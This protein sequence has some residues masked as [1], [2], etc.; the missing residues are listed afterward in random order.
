MCSS[1]GPY[2]YAIINDYNRQV[3]ISPNNTGNSTSPPN[4]PTNVVTSIGFNYEVLAV[5]ITLAFIN[6]CL[7]IIAIMQDKR[8]YNSLKMD[9]YDVNDE[10]L[11]KIAMR[12]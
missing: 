3:P 6:I 10:F 5:I 12:K 11:K 9:I 2:F 8:D 4:S 1:I 7:P